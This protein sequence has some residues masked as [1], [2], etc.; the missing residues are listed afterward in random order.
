[1]SPTVTTSEMRG[2]ESANHGRNSRTGVS[3]PTRPPALSAATTVAL[4]GLEIEA[5]GK[6]V[7]ASTDSPVSVL[8]TPKPSASATSPLCTTATAAPGTPEASSSS[9]TMSVTFPIAYSMRSSETSSPEYAAGLCPGTGSGSGRPHAARTTATAA[10][11]AA[12]AARRGRV[13]RRGAG[14]GVIAPG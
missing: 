12:A 13:W 11:I 10:P 14:F 7:R 8:R 2:S 1:M 5:R 6:T 9:S 3:Q 4:T